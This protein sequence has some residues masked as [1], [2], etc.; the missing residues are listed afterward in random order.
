MI[1]I[2]ETVWR[3]V[4]EADNWLGVGLFT[5]LCLAAM[6]ICHLRQPR[7]VERAMARQKE[8]Q[9]LADLLLPQ[10]ERA[11]SLEIIPAS[12]LAYYQK[13]LGLGLDLPD[14]IPVK[15]PQ[16]IH[17]NGRWMSIPNFHLGAAKNAA[18]KRLHAMGVD[19]AA[20]LTKLGRS[21]TSKKKE[22]LAS[23]KTRVTEPKR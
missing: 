7:T 14:L 16:L 2:S 21:R 19:V 3:W 20:G 11:V 15:K 23:L 1:S 12:R 4:G 9:G 8:R 22:L 17:L 13:K 6:Y 10:L 5:A 18:L